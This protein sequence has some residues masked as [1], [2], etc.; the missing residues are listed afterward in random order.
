MAC[1]AGL[2]KH[3]IRS[4]RLPLLQPHVL[5]MLRVLRLASGHALLQGGPGSGRMSSARLAAFVSGCRV[6][7]VGTLSYY[8]VCNLNTEI[9]SPA[10]TPG[11]EITVDPEPIQTKNRATPTAIGT[12]VANSSMLLCARRWKAKPLRAWIT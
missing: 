11:R 1:C 10:S 4:E 9:L 6:F 3:I 8:L 2:G 7:E 12:C 5:R